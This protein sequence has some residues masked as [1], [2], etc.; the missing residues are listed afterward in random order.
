MNNVNHIAA[1]PD[2]IAVFA[3][4]N[5]AG[6]PKRGTL[7]CHIGR[8]GESCPDEPLRKAGVEAAGDWVFVSAAADERAHL[9]G[10]IM[11]GVV[12]TDHANLEGGERGPVGPKRKHLARGAKHHCAPARAV[13]DPL[14]VTDV[15]GR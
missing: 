13:V 4:V 15:R 14:V 12:R 2:S 1:D 5:A 3:Q 8:R 7:G 10:R 9:E 11:T 6:A